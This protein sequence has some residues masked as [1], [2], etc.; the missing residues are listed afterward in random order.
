MATE[1]LATARPETA[2]VTET[3]GVKTPSARVRHVPKRLYGQQLYRER[4][5]Q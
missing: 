3:A 2:L 5:A 1:G 4:E